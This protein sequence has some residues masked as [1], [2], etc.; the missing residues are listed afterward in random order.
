MPSQKE[1][2]LLL[3]WGLENMTK[4]KLAL[5]AKRAGASLQAGCGIV[6]AMPVSHRRVS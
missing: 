5:G 2:V 6:V 1:L 3:A 4:F